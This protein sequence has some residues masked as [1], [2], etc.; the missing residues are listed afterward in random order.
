MQRYFKWDDKTQISRVSDMII[1]EYFMSG[2]KDIVIIN[3]GTD[4]CI[5]DCLGPLVGSTI[6]V[7][8]M[9]NVY[10]YGT[11]DAPIHAINMKERLYEIYEKHPDAFIIGIDACLGERDHIGRIAVRDFPI[12][13]GKGVGKRLPSVGDISIIGVVDDSESDEFFVTRP[14]RL[15]FIFKLVNTIEMLLKHSLEIINILNNEEQDMIME[16]Q[17]MIEEEISHE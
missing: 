17:N 3:I 10:V 9:E 12:S 14:I 8:D 2:K 5:G 4:K 6:N 16:E 7:D 13:P 1:T 15:S 11:L